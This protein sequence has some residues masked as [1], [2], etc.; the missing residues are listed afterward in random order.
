MTTKKKKAR[1]LD[2]IELPPWRFI[3]F[4]DLHMSARTLDRALEVMRR[5]R[6]LALESDARVVFCGDFW[7]ARG[8]L[9]VRQVAPLLDEL[10]EWQRAGI[11][12][13]FIPGNHDQV[14]VDGEIHGVKIFEP[15]SNIH[16]ATKRLLWPEYK[17]AF[18]PWREDPTEQQEQITSLHGNDWTVFGHFEV[19][20]ATTNYAHVAPGRILLSQLRDKTR[21]CYG[22]HY[23]KTQ[24]LGDRMWYVG[25][26][27]QKDFGEIDDPPK[28]VALITQDQLEP[29]W[30]HLQGFPIHHRVTMGKPYVV[31]NIARHD[32]VEVYHEPDA[33]GSDELA[34]FIDSIP[35][36]DVRPLPIKV[37]KDEDEAPAFAL[38]IDAA[39]EQ[40]VETEFLERERQGLDLPM[41][42]D[43]LEGLGKAIL[44]ELP[45]ARALNPLSTRVDILDVEITDFCAIRGTVKLDL[46]ERGLMLLR[47]PV[48]TGKTAFVDALTW[49]LYGS[50]NPRKAGS[51]NATF[52]GDEVIHDDA[53]DTAVTV[54]VKHAD[55]REIAV[56][57]IKERGKGA[58]VTIE[59]IDVPD[60]VKDAQ[61]TIDRVIGLNQALWRACV[62]L[63]QGAVGNFVTDA[64][65]AR[66]QTLSTAFG[67]DVC[68]A[69]QKLAR[70]RLKPLLAEVSKMET[71]RVAVQSVL[72]TLEAQDYLTQSQEWEQKNT[73]AKDAAITSGEQ[74]KKAIETIDSQMAGEEEWLS[75][76][77]QHDTHV[78]QLTQELA[79]L[80]SPMQAAEIQKSIGAAQAE[81]TMVARDLAKAQNDLKFLESD[82]ASN[83]TMPCPTCGQPMPAANAEK[84]VSEKSQDIKRMESA[85]RSF[86]S[87]IENLQ[88]ELANVSRGTEE[89]RAAIGASIAESRTALET[90]GKALSEFSRMRAQRD[91]HARVLESARQTWTRLDA[92]ENPWKA[93]LDAHAKQVLEAKQR[94]ET[95][96][97]DIQ[98]L[99]VQAEALEF[100]EEAFGAK[101][102]PVLVLR[103]VLHELET[104]GNRFLSQI[105]GSRM[106][107]RLSMLGDSLGIQF[108][109]TIDGQVRERRYEQLSGGQRR[110]VELAFSPFALSEMVF[111]RAGVRIPLLIV[112]ELTTHL[113]AEEKPLVCELLRTLDRSTVLVIDHD[114]A[115]QSEFDTVYELARGLNAT[116]LG[117]VAA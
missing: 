89:K 108:F 33:L 70:S 88:V 1:S 111:S 109:E 112:D 82:Q 47:G 48:G 97:Q 103:T 54:R 5:V 28:G 80:G 63:G 50:T 41:A 94:L 64:D 4:S 79:Q 113:G 95:L 14:S 73:L 106:A 53:T 68:P 58:R 99:K 42:A 10:R 107:V 36:D 74:S 46:S 7:D 90:I 93:R 32:I 96:D 51:H 105:L 67:L 117:R 25:N 101:G 13:I 114:I 44:A 83:P 56:T 22:G 26:P 72:Q 39:V 8:V 81:K 9:A 2:D 69:A 78:E 65:T 30:I 16:V 87:R 20:G 85:I 12:A 23:H 116:S 71:D 86:D 38:S 31:S 104:H 77:R 52:R 102:I 45:E 19:E 57:R 66:K 27:F 60:G 115:V 76:K 110:C 11:E 34:E 40:W 59:G 62:S 100:W 17:L 6:T 55:G 21:A 84:F 61:N 15:F 29:Q 49:C 43:A 92:E 98:Q 24:K 75:R 3:A 18:I 35:A 91:E 37:E